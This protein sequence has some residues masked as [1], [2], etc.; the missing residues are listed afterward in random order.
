LSGQE[1]VDKERETAKNYLVPFMPLNHPK[2]INIE[3]SEIVENTTEFK[4]LVNEKDLVKNMDRW[5]TINKFLYDKNIWNSAPT[6]R[7]Y[8][9]EYEQQ[10]SK[11]YVY[12]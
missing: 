10:L 8:E 9:A 1:R 11:Y 2:V 5:Q 3:F 6:K 7:F 4:K 12:N